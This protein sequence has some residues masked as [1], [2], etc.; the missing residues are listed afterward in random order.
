MRVIVRRG[1]GRRQREGR[2]RNPTKE[3]TY[4]YHSPTL[5]FFLA[6][7]PWILVLSQRKS[8]CTGGSERWGVLMNV[9]TVEVHSITSLQTRAGV[10]G[11][12]TGFG[13]SRVLASRISHLDPLIS[14][15]MPS[16]S[17]AP[18]LSVAPMSLVIV[19]LLPDFRASSVPFSAS[20][21]LFSLP[22]SAD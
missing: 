5:A 16:P 15:P 2:P 11:K 18:P 1:G 21:S 3:R 22:L 20:A 13:G 7:I 14:A 12:D 19:F 8:W 6:V 17:P 9:R 10:G 4:L